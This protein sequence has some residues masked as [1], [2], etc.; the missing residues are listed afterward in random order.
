MVGAFIVASVL[1]GAGCYKVT[2]V[3][4]TSNAILDREISFSRDL[5]PIFESRCALGGCHSPGNQVPDLSDARAYES[6]I[7]EDLINFEDPQNSEL[8]DWL[9]GKRIPAMP[10]GGS[11]P[12]I[13]IVVLTWLSQGAQNN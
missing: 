5:L 8:Y 7:R 4:L 11:D 6:L 12:D 1:F 2:T 9:T 13:N 3:D 10:L